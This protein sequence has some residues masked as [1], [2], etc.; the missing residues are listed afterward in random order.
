MNMRSGLMTII[1]ASIL[2][3]FA[4]SAATYIQYQSFDP[5]VWM[6]QDIEAGRVQMVPRSSGHQ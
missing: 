6:E 3:T 2:L 1:G 4:A 5:C